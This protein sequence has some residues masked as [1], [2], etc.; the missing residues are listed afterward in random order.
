MTSRGLRR[1]LWSLYAVPLTV[2]LLLSENVA[3][4]TAGPVSFIDLLILLAQLLALYLYIW[5]RKCLT[6]TLWRF[7]ACGSLA[8]DVVYNLWLYPAV[9]GHPLMAIDLVVVPALIPLYVALFRYAFQDWREPQS[10]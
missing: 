9:T 6:A 2:V 5:D 3:I 7:F 8:W 10:L 1:L 4:R